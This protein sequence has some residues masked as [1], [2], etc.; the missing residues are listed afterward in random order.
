MLVALG[1]ALLT[2][3]CWCLIGIV[4]SQAADRGLH[5]A[6]MT[7]LTGLGVAALTAILIDWSA[8]AGKAQTMVVVSMSISGLAMT[9]G[10]IALQAAMQRGGH[11]AAWAVAQSGLA[12]PFLVA[13]LIHGERPGL[14]PWLGLLCIIASLLLL[15]ERRVELPLD[16]ERTVG[17]AGVRSS[18]ER[19]SE[20]PGSVA[21][22]TWFP[23][24]CLAWLMIGLQ[25][26]AFQWPSLTSDA[27]DPAG[28]R[29]PLMCAVG[30]LSA[31]LLLVSSQSSRRG[32]RPR[33]SL[34]IVV[35]FALLGCTANVVAQPAIARS[36]DLLA[37][38]G[39]G[40]IA[41]PVAIAT[42]ITLFVLYSCFHRGERPR[43]RACA[44]LAC[45]LS[46]VVLMSL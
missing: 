24:A 34:R 14:L 9:A 15:A 22:I 27:P 46:G 11:G 10:M 40:G 1:L 37:A 41:F 2:G 4:L 33:T 38:L 20:H 12:W 30:G 13:V 29:V 18:V 45:C 5:P 17:H 44:G 19:P 7:A 8:I 31:T 43:P 32:P 35:L 39:S 36:S 26:S 42:C 3:C 16:Q 25:Q 21:P 23:L 28:I 6:L